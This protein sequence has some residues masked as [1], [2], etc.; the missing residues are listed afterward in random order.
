MNLC[1][2]TKQAIM[3]LFPN[4]HVQIWSRFRGWKNTCAQ[5]LYALPC[6]LLLT[7]LCIPALFVQELMSCC[8]AGNVFT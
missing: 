4:A 6:A 2:L 3:P 1:P 8:V 7:H 5:E